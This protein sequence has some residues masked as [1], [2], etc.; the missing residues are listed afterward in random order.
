MSE[1]VN[2]LMLEFLDWISTRPRTY[3][4][5]MDAWQS[6]CP[7]QTIWEDAIIEGLIQLNRED[8]RHDPEVMLTPRGKALLNGNNAHR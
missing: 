4:E 2:L 5:T 7:R 3:A 6:H 8:T 1:S